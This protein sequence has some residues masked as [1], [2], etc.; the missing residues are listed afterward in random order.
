MIYNI[1]IDKTNKKL[2]QHST[3][4]QADGVLIT[5]HVS[6]AEDKEI[7]LGLLYHQQPFSSE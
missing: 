4:M 7:L 5:S 6:G 3:A 1:L 2:L